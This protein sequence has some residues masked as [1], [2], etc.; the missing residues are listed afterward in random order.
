MRAWTAL[1]MWRTGMTMLIAFTMLLGGTTPAPPAEPVKGCEVRTPAWCLVGAGIYWDVTTA[2]RKTRI[3]TLRD[4]AL[5]GTVISIREDRRCGSYP[6]DVHFRSEKREPAG[7]DGRA[8]HVITW[9]LHHAGSCTLW[10]EIPVDNE[11]QYESARYVALVS[12]MSC[13]NEGR[14][15]GPSLGE[16]AVVPADQAPISE[17]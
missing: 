5:P 9:S 3:W 4:P 2:D 6:A 13:R 17:W 11:R 8:K 1:A 16:S 12:L 15:L 14:C 10:I 7:P